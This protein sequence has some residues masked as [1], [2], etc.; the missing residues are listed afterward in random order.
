MQIYQRFALHFIRHAFANIY[1]RGYFQCHLFLLPAK[2]FYG[3]DDGCFIIGQMMKQREMS[4]QKITFRR[5]VLL[6]FL[7]EESLR[8]VIKQNGK[9]ER[10]IHSIDSKA[11]WLPDFYDLTVG[12][13]GVID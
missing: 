10:R 4:R 3:F 13:K 12:C 1:R 5:K 6:S 2:R 11:K 8:I 7:I 9:N